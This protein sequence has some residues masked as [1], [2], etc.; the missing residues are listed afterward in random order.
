MQKNIDMRLKN[1]LPL[2]FA[3]SFCFVSCE[4]DANSLEGCM[5]PLASNYNPDADVEGSCSYDLANVLTSRI[6][7]MT[8]VTTTFN[9]TDIDLLEG[10][11]LVPVC[12]QDNLLTFNPDNTLSSDENEVI[13]TDDEVS[14][15]DLSGTWS[16]DEYLL[17]IVNDN[18]TY[19]LPATGINASEISLEFTYSM[20]TI[21]LPATIV[22]TAY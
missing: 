9:D 1:I 5:D 15:V 6:W 16:V 4:E 17:T 2:L 14:L 22:L 8:S 13:C 19:S 21:E 12:Y 7:Q 10:G 3:L 18:E 11:E 20:G